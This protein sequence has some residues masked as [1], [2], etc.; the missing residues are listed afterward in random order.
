MKPNLILMRNLKCLSCPTLGKK[1]SINAVVHKK[2][3]W[4]KTCSLYA[5]IVTALPLCFSTYPLNSENDILF[6]F[7]F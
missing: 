5:Q 2:K 6:R 7:N 3:H 1:E 4:A